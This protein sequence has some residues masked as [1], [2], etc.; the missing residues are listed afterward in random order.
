[1]FPGTA[2]AF[3]HREMTMKRLIALAVLLAATVHPV[4]ADAELAV[5]IS[6]GGYVGDRLYTAKSVQP[7]VWT[8]PTG[9]NS[10][11]GDELLVDVE[12]WAQFG[13][14]GFTTLRDRWGLKFDLGFTDVDVDGKVRDPSGA[15]ETVP[16]EQLFIF[17][18]IAQATWRL[19]NSEDSYPYLALGPALTVASGEG[20]SLDQTMPGLAWGA[21][22]RISAAERSWFE[23]GVRGIWQWPDWADEESRLAADEFNGE[24][25]IHSLSGSVAVGYVY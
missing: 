23:I 20:N 17:D 24:T 22:W 3:A 16:W 9:S 19:G 10:G 13:L 5:G 4:A 21:G 15:S 1:M 11:A 14:T 6:V 12:S 8:N 25:M 18:I 7:R 2:T